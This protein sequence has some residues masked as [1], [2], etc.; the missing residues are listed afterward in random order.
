[1]TGRGIHTKSGLEMA[2]KAKDKYQYDDFHKN[3]PY[4]PYNFPVDDEKSVGTM[5][6]YNGITVD[7]DNNLNTGVIEQMSGH[8]I[9]WESSKQ[10]IW[11]HGYFDVKELK[12]I[13]WWMEN[14]HK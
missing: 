2:E 13:I 1:M 6:G 4:M 7:K 8:K 5:L 14:K 10:Y 12:A 3:F 9:Y 11:M